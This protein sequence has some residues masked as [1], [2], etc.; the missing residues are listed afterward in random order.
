VL[1]STFPGCLQVVVIEPIDESTTCQ[2][3]YLITDIDE[4]DTE[5][6]D[7]IFEGQKFAA[8]GAIEDQKIVMSA[9][10]GLMSGANEYLEFSLFESAISHLHT[11]LAKEIELLAESKSQ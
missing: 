1:I 5:L 11:H 3:T 6:L 9:Q 10:R 7:S 2:H 8:N 4:N